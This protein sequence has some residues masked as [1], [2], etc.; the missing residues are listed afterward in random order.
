M[1]PSHDGAH[2]CA[3]QCY[4]YNKSRSESWGSSYMLSYQPALK[5]ALYKA[6]IRYRHNNTILCKTALKCIWLDLRTQ[7]GSNL[8]HVSK[9]HV[10]AHAITLNK[11]QPSL[12]VVTVFQVGIPA[13]FCKCEVLLW[14]NKSLIE[15]DFKYLLCVCVC[16]CV[17]RCTYLRIIFTISRTSGV[18]RC[19][20]PRLGKRA[21]S[22]MASLIGSMKVRLNYISLF[23]KMYT[24]NIWW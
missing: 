23:E 1:F 2:L 12:S 17:C 11:T 13:L 10:R 22:I 6:L 4:E 7:A 15:I 20:W 8:S 24:R 21:S 16:V 18:T 9:Q 14:F 3:R 19:D 5:L